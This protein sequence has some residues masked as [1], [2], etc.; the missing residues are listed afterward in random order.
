MGDN[1]EDVF[2]EDLRDHYEHGIHGIAKSA[3]LNDEMFFDLV[4]NV[5]KQ[6]N[7]VDD[8]KLSV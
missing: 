4:Q 6:I 8:G 5:A 1:V 3:F 7:A 2:V